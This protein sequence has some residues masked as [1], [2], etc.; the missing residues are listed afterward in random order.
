[1][2]STIHAGQRCRVT[3]PVSDKSGHIDRHSEG[4]VRY[5]SENLGRV[6]VMVEW[7]RGG[8][9]VLFPEEVEFVGVA[10]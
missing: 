1:M 5:V 7:D 3:R 4:R 8:S 10:A 2:T 6:L 9:S